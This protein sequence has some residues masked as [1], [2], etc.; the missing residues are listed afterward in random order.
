M[1]DALATETGIGHGD[2]MSVLDGL[3]DY[4]DLDDEEAARAAKW[5]DDQSKRLAFVPKVVE[6]YELPDTEIKPTPRQ[7][8]D[9]A[10]SVAFRALNVNLR[11][12]PR[13]LKSYERWVDKIDKATKERWDY[14]DRVE[15]ESDPPEDPEILDLGLIDTWRRTTG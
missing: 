2:A 14:H 15:G 4:S 6:G 13:Y 11:Q 12:D 1:S 7:I 3:A 8:A 5:A 10:A 9:A